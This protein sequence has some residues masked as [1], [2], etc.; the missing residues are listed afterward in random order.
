MLKKSFRSAD[1]S[2]L[3]I[4]SPL[5]YLMR[6]PLSKLPL[7]ML[8]LLIFQICTLDRHGKYLIITENTLILMLRL[9]GLKRYVIEHVI[10]ARHAHRGIES[11]RSNT[12]SANSHH[13]GHVQINPP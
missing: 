6:V 13:A 4:I 1:N 3:D 7:P 11:T 10:I 9:S 2:L 8:A 5:L 12:I